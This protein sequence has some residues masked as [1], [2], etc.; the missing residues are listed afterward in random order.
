MIQ[1]FCKFMYGALHE[2]CRF[3]NILELTEKIINIKSV[4]LLYVAGFF[5]GPCFLHLL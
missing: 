4:M 5:S 3:C 1:G 2:W